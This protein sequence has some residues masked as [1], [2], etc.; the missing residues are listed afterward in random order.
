MMR[1]N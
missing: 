1:P